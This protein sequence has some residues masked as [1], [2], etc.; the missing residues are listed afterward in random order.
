MIHNLCLKSCY[1]SYFL[2]RNLYLRNRFHGLSPNLVDKQSSH[3]VPQRFTDMAL[4]THSISHSKLVY[5]RTRQVARCLPFG[6]GTCPI[7]RHRLICWISYHSSGT[8]LALPLYAVLSCTLKLSRFSSPYVCGW[9]PRLCHCIKLNRLCR[10]KNG[11]SSEA[12]VRFNGVITVPPTSNRQSSGYVVATS[13]ASSCCSRRSVE[14]RAAEIG[15]V[16][17]VCP[18]ACSRWISSIP[19]DCLVADG[20]RPAR[21]EVRLSLASKCWCARLDVHLTLRLPSS[22]SKNCYGSLALWNSGSALLSGF[23]YSFAIFSSN[24]ALFTS[25]WTLLEA[26]LK[27]KWTYSISKRSCSTL[28]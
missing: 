25:N 8:R 21:E 3:Q 24:C 6:E 9:L 22:Y 23:S 4:K 2:G 1:M 5:S 19:L 10:R 7:Y 27:S 16:V 12:V 17:N 28:W 26:G 13:G 18:C 11:V 20:R 15:F 14:R